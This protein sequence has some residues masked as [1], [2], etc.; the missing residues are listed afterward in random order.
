MNN[1][2]LNKIKFTFLRYSPLKGTMTLKPRLEVIQGEND[3]I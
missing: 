3:G 2:Q 1:L